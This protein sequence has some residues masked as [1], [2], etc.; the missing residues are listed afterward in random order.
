MSQV[1]FDW[2][3]VANSYDSLYQWS[4]KRP[5]QFWRSLWDYGNVIGE[6]GSRIVEDLEK[7]PGA[8]WF[9]DAR[10]NYAE[11]LLRYR[12]DEHGIVFHREDSRKTRMTSAELYDNVARLAAAMRSM[13]IT[14]G[15]RVVTYMPNIPET[16][17]AMLATTSIGAI[18]SSC[19][20]D[21]G[22]TGVVDRFGQIEPKLF[23]T[24]DKY[25]YNGK[26]FDASKKAATISRT[27]S[28]KSTA[29]PVPN[30]PR[31]PRFPWGFTPGTASSTS[32][33]RRSSPRGT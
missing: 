20:P 8:K 30:R 16:L 31:T 5:D 24:I 29:S 23:F 14:E 27:C 1:E 22:V 28:T 26:Q 6:A 9:P 3:C 32:R 17:I 15:D 19:S 7:V 4:I 25:L 11:N 13:G 12:D 10:L 18:F 2:G 21:F 33:R